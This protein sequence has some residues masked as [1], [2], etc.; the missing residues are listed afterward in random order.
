MATRKT[1]THD[2]KL[3]AVKLITY[4]PIHEGWLYFA[5]VLNLYSRRVVGHACKASLAAS[6]VT[7]VPK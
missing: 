7:D 4:V 2:F 6:L 3:D 5:V 1:Y